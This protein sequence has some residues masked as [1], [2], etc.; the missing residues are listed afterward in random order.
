MSSFEQANLKWFA[1]WYWIGWGWVA[2]VWFLSLTSDPLKVDFGTTFN[3][4]IGHTLAYG[5]LMFWFGNLYYGRQA[6]FWLL[7]LFIVMGAVLEG[8]QSFNPA[9]QFGVDDMLANTVGVIIG[10]LL[11]VGKGRRIFYQIELRLGKTV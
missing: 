7:V 3:D 10:Y 11:T 2:L 1:R 6:R 4:K 8:I 9:R 5:W